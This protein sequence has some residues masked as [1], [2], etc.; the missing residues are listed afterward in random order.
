M[1]SGYE[2]YVSRESFKFNAAHFIAYRGF[3]ERLHGHNYRVSVRLRGPVGPDGYVVD[4]DACTYDE[5][6]RTHEIVMVRH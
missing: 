5:T 3:R 2:I 1:K 4:Q 6:T